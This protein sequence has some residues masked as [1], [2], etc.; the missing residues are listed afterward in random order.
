MP[1]DHGE[2]LVTVL[3]QLRDE[4]RSHWKRYN[5]SVPNVLPKALGLIHARAAYDIHTWVSARGDIA[6]VAYIHLAFLN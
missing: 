1:E 4:Q 3:R 2:I 5:A 6:G